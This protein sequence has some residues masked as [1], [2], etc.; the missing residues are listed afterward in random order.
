VADK[1]VEPPF[2]GGSQP[3]EEHATGIRGGG[4]GAVQVVV[5][6]VAVLLVLAAVLWFA[7]P[8][9]IGGR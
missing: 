1:Q 2:E 6:A 7:V 3:V 9:F 8:I 4:R 5:V